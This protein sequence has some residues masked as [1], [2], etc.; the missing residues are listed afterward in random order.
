MADQITIQKKELPEL[1]KFLEKKN[2]KIKEI[3]DLGKEA[4]RV[5]VEDT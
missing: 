1:K 3:V 5:I 2:K 4:I